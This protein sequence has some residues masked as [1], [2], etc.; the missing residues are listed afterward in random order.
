M[1]SEKRSVSESSEQA[2]FLPRL[3]NRLSLNRLPAENEV[4]LGSILEKFAHFA[5][6]RGIRPF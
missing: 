6:E 5:V 1:I 3:A 4:W 2:I